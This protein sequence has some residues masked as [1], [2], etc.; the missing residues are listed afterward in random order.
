M[1]APLSDAE[2][3]QAAR[4]DPAAFDRL[5]RRYLPAV[6]R[7]VY[8][9]VGSAADAEDVTSA[10][11]LD[12]LTSLGHY[13]EQGLF[14]AWL[15]TIAQRQVGA[16]H[17]RWRREA[18]RRVEPRTGEGDD[19]G[20]VVDALASGDSQMHVLRVEQVD[21]LARAVAGLSEDQREAL[22]LRFYGGLK[23]SEIAEVMGK[24]ESAV[25]MILHRSL[26]QLKAGLLPIEDR[27]PDDRDAP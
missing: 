16:H 21:L 7:Y 1:D 13:R 12:V 26:S 9:R 24:G 22:S 19:G 27:A 6:Y 10:I 15:F 2:L 25:K 14:T 11:F 3:A 18:A 23:V 5:Y 8:A 17:R 4:H 20:Q